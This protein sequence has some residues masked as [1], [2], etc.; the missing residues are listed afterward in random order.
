[1]RRVPATFVFNAEL[2]AR[3]RQLRKRAR[4]SLPALAL[5]MGRAEGY[6]NRLARLE[7]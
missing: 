6:H 3:M 2:G 4:L 1:M 7:A 5:R